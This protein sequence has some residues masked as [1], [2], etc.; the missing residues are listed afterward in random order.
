MDTNCEI[1][2]QPSTIKGRI[3]S[4]FTWKLVLAVGIGGLLGFLYY[5]FVGCP[6]GNCTISS[7]PYL[8]VLWGSLMG[9]FVVNSPCSRGRC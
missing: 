7:S 4:W 9:L 2:E 5:Y 8:S 6:S 1:K 3:A